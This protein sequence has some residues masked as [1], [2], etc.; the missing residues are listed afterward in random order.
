[1]LDSVS[2]LPIHV[3][4]VLFDHLPAFVVG[5]KLVQIFDG[6]AHRGVGCHCS[7]CDCSGDDDYAG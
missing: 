5:V 4:I 1:M 2:I 6:E 3:A 7:D